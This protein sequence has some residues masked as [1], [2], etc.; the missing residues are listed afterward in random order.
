MKKIFTLDSILTPYKEFWK[1]CPLFLYGISYLLGISAAL[2]HCSFLYF[3]LAICFFFPLKKA[4]FFLSLAVTL[5]GYLLALHIAPEPL[6]EGAM[7][8]G[9]GY[10]SISS[11][12]PSTSFVPKLTYKGTL[13]YFSSSDK[14]FSTKQM[15]CTVYFADIPNH[16]NGNF[17]YI[18]CGTL[19]SMSPYATVCKVKKDQWILK[20]PNHSL[21]ELRFRVKNFC[22]KFFITHIFHKRSADFLSALA[23]GELDENFIKFSFANLG[24]QYIMVISGFH[25]G[26]LV[27][28]LA[29][30]LRPFLS[31]RY[32]T[33]TL[34]LLVNLYFLFLGTS[35][36]VERAWISVQLVLLG[37]LLNKRTFSI[38]VLGL[39]L[40]IELFQDPLNALNIGFQLSFLSTAYIL[41]GYTPCEK[42]FHRFLKKHEPYS[43]HP[44]S[45]IGEK[46]LSLL[47]EGLSL[48]IVVNLAVIPVVLFHFHT[49]P[50]L[51]FFYNLFFPIL[52]GIVIF[53]IVLLVLCHLLLPPL[54][55]VMDFLTTYFTK[56]TLDFVS[57]PPVSLQYSIRISE[58]S[59]PLLLIYIA[60]ISFF[61][62]LLKQRTKTREQDVF[63][64]L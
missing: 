50:L 6:T 40:L 3:F 53:L 17:D 34:L 42:M 33:I 41:L 18:L 13:H 45:Q 8:E 5:F 15:P 54:G 12:S 10:F 48:T 24:L 27:L 37:K 7:Y 35:P 16:P 30:L 51:G 47:R 61:F 26:I 60:C 63:Q 20:R 21:V 56:W 55:F 28:S 23:T 43:L 25:F 32:L 29:L 62:V 1:E 57:F 2:S 59:T 36:P 31:F 46:I 38:N 49:F 64:I 19:F 39:A 11:I 14:T 9:T 58:I 52:I 22:R 44:L 4:L